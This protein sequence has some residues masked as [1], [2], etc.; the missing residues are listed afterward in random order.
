MPNK[1]PRITRQKSLV[2]FRTAPRPALPKFLFWEIRYETMDWEGGYGTVIERVTEWGNEEEWLEVI[3][4]YGLQKVIHTLKYESTY[5]PDF[6]IS[7]VSEYFKLKQEE[8]RCY[9]RKQSRKGHW[10]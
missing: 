7:K 5:L 6:T 9:T 3:R 10:I 1:I 2:G 4:F 8:L